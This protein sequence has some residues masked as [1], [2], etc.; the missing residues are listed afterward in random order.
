MDGSTARRQFVG[1]NTVYRREV[2]SF[3]PFP[4]SL[5][6]MLSI[7]CYFNETL[8]TFTVWTVPTRSTKTVLLVKY[9]DRNNLLQT[10]SI[11]HTSFCETLP[12]IFHGT[13]VHSQLPSARIY[14]FEDMTAFSV[15]HWFVL[16]SSHCSSRLGDYF[17]ASWT[18]RGR[19]KKGCL[20]VY[21]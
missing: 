11:L 20:N 6:S 9:Y 13:E 3:L 8:E 16:I 4:L 10:N 5:S 2:W 1:N 14:F 7:L 12:I 21:S 19:M 17:R 15:C 18:E